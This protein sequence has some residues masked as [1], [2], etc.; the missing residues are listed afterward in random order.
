MIMLDQS[1]NAKKA[2][3]QQLC[4][5]N[6]AFRL[7]KVADNTRIQLNHWDRPQIQISVSYTHLTLPTMAV[8]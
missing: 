2:V 5:S 4:N 8:V 1:L 7:Q 3:V 6:T